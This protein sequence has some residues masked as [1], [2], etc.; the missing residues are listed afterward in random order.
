MAGRGTLGTQ[1]V[2]GD[3]VHMVLLDMMDSLDSLDFR[4]VGGGGGGGGE[5]PHQNTFFMVT[6]CHCFNHIKE[7]LA[8]SGRPQGG[9]WPFLAA[10]RV[11]FCH[12][13]KL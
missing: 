1:V 2:G 3:L 7:N 10:L 6:I 9:F 11:V 8:F 13:I 5:I 12:P 4:Y